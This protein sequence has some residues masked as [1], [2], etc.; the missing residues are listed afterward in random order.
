MSTGDYLWNGTTSNSWIT[1]SNWYVLNGSNFDMASVLPTSSDNVYIVS[2]TTAGQ[3]VS[4]VNNATVINGNTGI[5]KNI[6]IGTSATVS[7]LGNIDVYGDYTND[8]ILGTGSGTSTVSF[9]GSANQILKSGGTGSSPNK[10]F[11]NIVIDKTAGSVSP[12]TGT[13]GDVYVS[14]IT[15]TNGTL[16]NS[17][18]N[19]NMTVIGTWTNTSATALFIPGTA[20][21]TFSS[22]SNL[23]IHTG[24]TTGSVPSGKSF[25]NFTKSG[26]GTHTLNGH[27]N[28]LN[29]IS[30]TVG[31]LS[32]SGSSYDIYLAGNWS[33]SAG[34]I[35]TPNDA[36]VRFAHS[37]TETPIRHALSRVTTIPSCLC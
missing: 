34:S 18:N 8:G 15:F 28:A 11:I 3:C 19:R 1:T 7:F 30:I 22:S 13:T 27:L 32:T 35:F 9:K 4:S 24:W 17:P 10:R 20:T 5:T 12:T 31:T 29:N 14:N 23:T 25:Y 16:D 37:C 26:A 6:Y 21:V 33:N 36:S 2:S